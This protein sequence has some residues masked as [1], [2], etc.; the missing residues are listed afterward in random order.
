MMN[1]ATTFLL[2]LGIAVI[3]GCAS[4]GK[5]VLSAFQREDVTPEALQEKMNWLETDITEGQTHEQFRIVKALRYQTKY[6]PDLE[7]RKLAIRKLT[8]IS[9]FGDDSDVRSSAQARLNSILNNP[10][11]NVDLQ[12]EVIRGKADLALGRMTYDEKVPSLFTNELEVKPVY[13][14]EDHREAALMFLIDH[15]EEQGQ[16]LQQHIVT[17]FGQ[18]LDNQPIC[19]EESNGN[20]EEYDSDVQEEWKQLLGTQIN[21]WTRNRCSWDQNI[22]SEEMKTSLQQLISRHKDLISAEHPTCRR[23]H[24]VAEDYS[25][26]E[27]RSIR[28]PDSYVQFGLDISDGRSKGI[29]MSNLEFGFGNGKSFGVIFG[30]NINEQWMEPLREKYLTILYRP[31]I[32]DHT[33]VGATRTERN[34]DFSLVES[35]EN[36]PDG[37]VDDDSRFI[38]EKDEN[39]LFVSSAVKLESIP[40][41][42]HLYLGSISQKL[43]LQYMFRQPDISFLMEATTRPEMKTKI[44]DTDTVANEDR[45]ER[46]SEATD[47]RNDILI[48]AKWN[49]VSILKHIFADRSSRDG[50]R[51]IFN[52]KLYHSMQ[53]H[54]TYFVITSPF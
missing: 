3:S 5:H 18:I 45:D 49:N 47:M 53:R 37:T 13:P 46:N 41:F 42:F 21:Y 50:R 36:D 35:G 9:A 27:I 6:N 22:I 11:E 34:P 30:V 24:P 2:V 43:G 26:L 39:E 40:A 51:G 8:F 12:I 38:F 10:D 31:T 19:I 1:R 29:H 54:K 28:I 14:D 23:Y 4:Q 15:F 44:R 16:D 7:K 32:N 20:C 33:I 52:F 48:G 17:A 25:A